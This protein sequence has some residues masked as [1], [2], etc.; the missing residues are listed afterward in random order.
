M[1]ID[2]AK[3]GMRVVLH[4]GTEDSDAEWAGVVDMFDDC[5]AT[6][7]SNLTTMTDLEGRTGVIDE[8][9]YALGEVLVLVDDLAP[10]A[11]CF[12]I[13]EVQPQ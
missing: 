7:P 11:I 6:M 13:S 10:V 1:D 5:H 2:Q 3:R 8:V 9:E 4:P 12:D